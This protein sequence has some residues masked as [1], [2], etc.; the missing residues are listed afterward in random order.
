MINVI[1][2]FNLNSNSLVVDLGAGNGEEIE[3]C[4]EKNVRIISFEPNPVLFNALV[5]KYKKYTNVVLRKE[6]AWISNG[7]VNLYIKNDAKE[8]NGGATL[9]KYKTNINKKNYISVKS[10]D[11]ASFICSLGRTIDVLK[12]DVEGAE[13]ELLD[14]LF[15]TKS[16]KL[17]KHIYFEDHT[18][19]IPRKEGKIW[20]KMKNIVLDR[21]KENNIQL[22]DW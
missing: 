4:V 2:E 10:I 1:N 18:R 21:Y 3:A 13:Y 12:I 11:I 14:R 20:R 8:K 17:I 15:N 6:A 9:I 7:S 19:K 5:K 22:F 16:V